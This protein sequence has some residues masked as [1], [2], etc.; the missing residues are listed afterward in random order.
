M[1]ALL[2]LLVGLFPL[3]LSAQNYEAYDKTNYYEITSPAFVRENLEGSLPILVDKGSKF[4][5]IGKQ[6]DDFLILFWEWQDDN[7]KAAKL[8]YTSINLQ[9]SKEKIDRSIENRRVFVLK[10]NDMKERAI[11]YFNKGAW[12]WAGGFV[13]LP[14]KIRN[15]P[16]RT[17]SKD[18]SL[19]FSGGGKVRISGYNPTYLNLLVNVGI[20]SVSLDSLS[21]K[22][23]IRQ[24]ADAAALTTALGVVLETHA[25]QFGLFVG[26]DR[27]SANDFRRSAWEY[28]RKPWI[29]LGLG[30]QILSKEDRSKAK[31]EGTNKSSP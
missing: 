10:A 1:K 7:F 15:G 13:L 14:V 9:D 30:Y 28:N 17:Y 5:L 6:G 20:S 21:T 26:T 18:L 25:F 12:N 2:V 3:L 8:N 22:G 29:S 31:S 19:G 27:L 16:T 11:P 4:T 23:K 24:P